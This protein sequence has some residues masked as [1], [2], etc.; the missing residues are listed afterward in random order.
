MDGLKSINDGLGHNAGDE[1]LIDIADILRKTFRE[2][3]ILARI[4]GDEFAVLAM[5]VSTSSEVSNLLTTRLQENLDAINRHADR[6]YQLSLSV[7]VAFLEPDSP[8]TLEELLVEADTRMYEHKRARKAG[9]L[10][11]PS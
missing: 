1:A 11:D 5:D 10:L 9:A 2:S 3:D 4:G 7:G 6:P 8:L